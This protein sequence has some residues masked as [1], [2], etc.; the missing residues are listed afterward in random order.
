[1]EPKL[2]E[3]LADVKR[4]N[5]IVIDHVSQDQVIEAASLRRARAR[6]RIVQ[7]FERFI[8]EHKDEITALQVLYT[9]P[10]SSASSSRTSK[11]SPPA[12]RPH[13]TCGPN[14]SS[15]KPTPR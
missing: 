3:L 12:S 13:R 8:E 1:M 5:E 6:P 2:R 10:T 9:T 14:R 15:G 7:S 4:K 11:T